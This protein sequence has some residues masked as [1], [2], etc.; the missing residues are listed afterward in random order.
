MPN[1]AGGLALKVTSAECAKP[2]RRAT[3][4]A[5]KLGR[6]VRLAKYSDDPS[7]VQRKLCQN[8]IINSTNGFLA[9]DTSPALIPFSR[10]RIT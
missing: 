7:N 5:S 3:V 2:Y 1:A 6:F 10:N 9:T 4:H 8:Q